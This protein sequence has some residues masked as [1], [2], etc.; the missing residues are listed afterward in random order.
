LLESPGDRPGCVD[1]RLIGRLHLGVLLL[2]RLDR[3]VVRVTLLHPR[4]PSVVDV[5]RLDRP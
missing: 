4:C 5:D 1:E 3:A 2:E